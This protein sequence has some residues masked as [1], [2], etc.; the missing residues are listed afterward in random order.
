MMSR[1]SSRISREY[2]G[3]AKVWG[4]ITKL[5]LGPNI[6]ADLGQGFPDFE[7]SSKARGEAS[8]AIL[9]M[10]RENQYSHSLYQD[11]LCLDKV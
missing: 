7:G 1:V 2:G 6:V 9:N 11:Y 3:G 4:E 10:K 5:A 8:N